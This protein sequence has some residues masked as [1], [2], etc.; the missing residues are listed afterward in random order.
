[1]RS[2][3]E[4]KITA[5]VIGYFVTD[6]DEFSGGDPLV[7]LDFRDILA[8]VASSRFCSRAWAI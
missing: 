6:G 4:S 3:W 7:E 1:V 8:R 2:N 5:R